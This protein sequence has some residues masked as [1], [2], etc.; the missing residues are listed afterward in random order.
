MKFKKGDKVLYID[1]SR[2][3]Q[4]IGEVIAIIKSPYP[5]MVQL[6]NCTS[7]FTPEGLRFKSYPKEG[8]ITKLNKLAQVL[9]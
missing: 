5:I 1:E 6:S 7:G 2:N 3:R 9:K 8:R 4:E